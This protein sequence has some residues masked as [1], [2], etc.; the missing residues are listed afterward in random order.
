MSNT[1]TEASKLNSYHTSDLNFV[2]EI[3]TKSIFKSI[4]INGTI[5]NIFDKE[6]VDRGYT[7]L[8]DW[9]ESSSFEVQGYYPQ[10]TR[11][12]LVGMTLKF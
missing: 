6:Y 3:N 10:A 11:N 9:D 8:N 4:V 7:Y 5:N 2:Y 1:D 12:F